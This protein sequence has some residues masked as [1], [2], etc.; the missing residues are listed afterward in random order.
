M[1]HFIPFIA[2]AAA[3]MPVAARADTIRLTPEQAEAAQEAGAAKRQRAAETGLSDQPGLDRGVHG[4]VGV[5]VGTGGYRSVYGVAALPLGDSGGVV[6]GYNNTR[7]R[8]GGPYRG[9]LCRGVDAELC[10]WRLS[11]DDLDR[12]R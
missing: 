6:L 12:G 7:G 10:D 9:D 3:I 5:S 11:A 4:E 2:L 1:R 8:V